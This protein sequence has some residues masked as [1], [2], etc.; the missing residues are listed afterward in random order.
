MKEASNQKM[1]QGT[2]ILEFDFMLFKAKKTQKKLR[3]RGK[4]PFKNAMKF[5]LMHDG[6]F[7]G[8]EFWNFLF[9]F[10]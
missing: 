8:G 2:L 1:L 9:S 4:K 3:T 10:F 7:F 5:F 6:Q